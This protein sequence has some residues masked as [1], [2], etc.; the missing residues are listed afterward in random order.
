MADVADLRFDVSAE[1]KAATAALGSFAQDVQKKLVNAVRALP[2]IE[3]TADSTD[4]QKDMKKLRDELAELANKKVGVDISAED[5]LAEM[6]RLQTELRTLGSSTTEVG[7]RADVDQASRALGDVEAEIQRLQGTDAEVEVTADTSQAENQMSDFADKAKVGAAAIGAAA[8]GLLAAGLANS[9]EFGAA[10][11][12]LEAQLGGTAEYS[13]RIGGLAGQLYAGAYGENLAEVGDAIRMVI[14]QIDGMGTASDEELTTVTAQVM[15]LAQAF[16]QD[17]GGTVNAVGQMLKTG[18]ADNAEHAL[19]ILTVGFQQG[20]DKAGDLLDT[21]IEYGTQFRKVG[22]EGEAAMGLLS[23]GLQGGARDADLVADAI[24]E[25]SIRSVDGSKEAAKSFQAL[26]IDAEEMQY[27]FAKGGPEAAAALDQ[28]FDALRETEGASNAAE[29]AFGLFGTQSEDLGAALY[30]LDPSAAAAKL[31]DVADAAGRLDATIG[32]SAEAK[33]TAMQRAFDQWTASLIETEGPLG[34]VGTMVAAFGPMAVTAAAAVAPLVLALKMGGVV[35]AL[36]GVSGAAAGTGAA[37]GAAATGGGAKLLS[38]LGKVG[39]LAGV[40]G[41]AFLID[42]ATNQGLSDLLN[43]IAGLP[44][45]AQRARDGIGPDFWSQTFQ[46]PAAKPGDM[47]DIRNIG[48]TVETLR[49]DFRTEVLGIKLP[50][51]NVDTDLNPAGA[52]R[53]FEMLLVDVNNATA[54]VNING[55]DTGAGFALR[56]ILDEIAAGAETIMINGEPMPALDA[57]NMVKAMINAEAGELSING[58]FGPAGDMMAA[59]MGEVAAIRGAVTIGAD[60]QEATEQLTTVQSHINQ[61]MGTITI[62]GNQMPADQALGAVLAA[63]DSG[64]ATVDINGNEVPA[65]LAL[66]NLI[67]LI[68]QGAGTVM[69]NGN[70]VP[71]GQ[72]LAALIQ[73][74][75]SSQ[76]TAIING[77]PTPGYSALSTF[78]S[79]GNR[80]VTTPQVNAATA[81]AYNQMNS[82]IASFQGR[83]IDLRV[84][85]AGRLAAG[86]VVPAAATFYAG[87]GVDRPMKKMPV[88]VPAV[89]QPGML[90]VFGDRSDVNESYIPW[91]KGDA[92]AVALLGVTADALGFDIS[93]RGSAWYAGGGVALSDPSAQAAAREIANRIQSGGQVY[94]DWSWKGA[95]AN[96]ARWNDTLLSAWESA[97]GGNALAWLAGVAAGPSAAAPAAA[98]PARVAQAV[99]A[100][101]LAKAQAGSAAAVAVADAKVATELGALR[102]EMAAANYG[103]AQLAELRGIRVDLVN[104]G[105]PSALSTASA[106]GAR[107]DGGAW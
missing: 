58:N 39:G 31:G 25:F 6:Q 95:S 102:R 46:S 18:L 65:G 36:S 59:F 34:E 90:R 70:E 86:A 33:V 54:T 45:A 17:L 50:A 5:A 61:T 41:A 85:T 43:H 20:N 100:S 2:D 4:A 16:D 97:G 69:I 78:L 40:V 87:G 104:S 72:V 106:A 81:N 71:A 37:A 77:E 30:D 91:K 10:Q 26:G 8:G 62:N 79:A 48:E 56:R 13:E 89:A 88:G 74:I 76:G 24:K 93:P 19:D 60:Y 101:P 68:D 11:A 83:T 53:A 67:G 107:A 52:Q 66:N 42:E 15:S 23:Q 29:I 12:R 82:F 14:Q 7:V 84:S 73:T 9:M 64:A 57:L 96:V 21:F 27:I 28:V 103:P 49:Q 44:D 99:T 63:I 3:I 1:T 51:L 92:R 94:E 47:N 32:G 80:S 98:A 38:V 105:R 35:A 55:N 75:S 22:I